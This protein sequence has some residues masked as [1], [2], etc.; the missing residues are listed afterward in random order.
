MEENAFLSNYYPCLIRDMDFPEL[1]YCSVLAAFQAAK[2]KN[3][4]IRKKFMGIPAAAAKELGYKLKLREDWA[5]VKEQYMENYLRE[6]F[7]D[8]SLHLKLMKISEL[9]VD[10]SSA[11][12][13]FW[14]VDGYVGENKL[15]FMLERLKTEYLQKYWPW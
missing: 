14:G 1:I 8:Q 3:P 11:S 2:T 5:E 10:H 6:K 7:H 13:T 15:G 9:I 12:D 4:E